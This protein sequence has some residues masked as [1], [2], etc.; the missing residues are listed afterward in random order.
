MRLGILS[1]LVL[2]GAIAH[3]CTTPASRR[4]SSSF[5]LPSTTV[6]TADELA[7][8]VG[9]G[10][11]LTALERVRPSM[12]AARAGANPF[13]SIDGSPP[14]DFSLL[15]SV[16]VSTVW[17][18]QLMRASSRMTPAAVADNGAIVVSDL[19]LVVTR[20]NRTR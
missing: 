4:Q 10:S 9:N 12:L 11:L 7:R 16:P 14:G 18:V 19:I 15:R 20:A 8:V 1:A 3:G 6:V 5:D 13:V 17:Q 2:A